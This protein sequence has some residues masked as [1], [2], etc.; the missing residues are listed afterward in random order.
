MKNLTRE[1][2]ED[3]YWKAEKKHREQLQYSCKQRLQEG[4]YGGFFLG[5][6]IGIIIVSFF[7]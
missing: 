3:A 2:L 5:I 4:F 6:I 1:E 7:K